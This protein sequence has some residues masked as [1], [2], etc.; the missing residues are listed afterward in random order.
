[1]V[2]GTESDTSSRS[3]TRGTKGGTKGGKENAREITGRM[4]GEERS[5]LSKERFSVAVSES[6]DV[7]ISM[8]ARG[9]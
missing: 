5:G 6:G 8:K 9:N 7:L 4:E 1:M 3:K 2:L